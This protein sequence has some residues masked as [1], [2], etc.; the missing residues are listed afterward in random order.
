MAEL[1]TDNSTSNQLNS[2]NEASVSKIIITTATDND[3]KIQENDWQLLVNRLYSTAD[4][5]I[6]SDLIENFLA[7]IKEWLDNFLKFYSF[8]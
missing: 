3:D 8:L 2:I 6:P 5:A 4:S 1:D 7:K